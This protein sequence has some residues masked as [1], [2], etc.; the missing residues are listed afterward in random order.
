MIQ[1][2]TA[3]DKYIA[4]QD[5][6]RQTDLNELR[7]TI[8][9]HLP[10]GFEETIS[11][12]MP[13]YVVPHA[14]FPRGYH[15]DP[16]HPL[17]FLSFANQKNFIALYHMGIYANTDLLEWFKAEY[18]NHS[19]RKIDMGKSCIRFKPAEIPMKLIGL[20]LQEMTPKEWIL[21]YESAVER[22]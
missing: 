20:L 21:L 8:V 19:K 12:G 11:Y 13:A 2:S 1:K 16:K 4:A 6:E 3:V 14:L 5:K 18:P 9:K 10:K 7:E 15:C 17:P 22:R